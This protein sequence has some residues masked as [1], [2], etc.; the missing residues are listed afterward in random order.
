MAV[1]VFRWEK[2]ETSRNWLLAVR[3]VILGIASTHAHDIVIPG[4][5][6]TPQHGS[7]LKDKQTKKIS[8][9]WLKI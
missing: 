8:S 4:A 5:R 7:S 6:S 2:D 3:Y 1:E 9:P